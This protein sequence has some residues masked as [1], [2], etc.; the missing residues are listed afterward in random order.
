MDALNDFITHHAA[1]AATLGFALFLGKDFVRDF[2][3][4]D[5]AAKLADNDPS[6]DKIARLEQ[7]AAQAIDKV[8]NPFSRK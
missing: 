2:L 7:S 1:L 3:A 6:N 8:P 4:R 5:S